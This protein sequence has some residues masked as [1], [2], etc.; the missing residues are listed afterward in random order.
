[1]PPLQLANRQLMLARE[2]EPKLRCCIANDF[3]L[4]GGVG[5]LRLSREACHLLLHGA[6]AAAAAAAAPR[7]LIPARD[8]RPRW[9]VVRRRRLESGE[10]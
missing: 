7:R 6:P 4:R 10:F 9:I 3:A 5:A 2:L 8:K 1:M